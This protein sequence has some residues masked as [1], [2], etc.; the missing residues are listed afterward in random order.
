MT[1][2]K[3]EL[4]SAVERNNDTLE[5]I[6]CFWQPSPNYSFFHAGT[7]HRLHNKETRCDYNHL[8]TEE[9]DP[10]YGLQEGPTLRAY[11][12]RYVYYTMEYDGSEYVTSILRNPE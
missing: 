1:T 11:T 9:Y 4:R 3:Q 8:P 12:A 5:N 6:V 2:I 10:G 7:E